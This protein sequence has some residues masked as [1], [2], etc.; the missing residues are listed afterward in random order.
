MIYEREQIT[1]EIR[2]F[3]ESLNYECKAGAVVVVEGQK[4]GI[5]LRDVGFNG[6]ILFNNNF[7]GNIK[8]VD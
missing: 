3:I 8:V 7:K 1:L 4:D 2:S 5:A 6:E